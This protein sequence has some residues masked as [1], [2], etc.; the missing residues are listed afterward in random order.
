MATARPK[1]MTSD[2]LLQLYSEGV[3]GELIRGVLS[4]TMP[5]GEM[6]GKVVMRLARLMGNHIEPR[7]LG[8]L[9]GSDAGVLLET[10]P[11]TVRE[12]DVAYFSVER[13]PLDAANPGFSQV[14]PDLVVEV[15]SPNDSHREVN[16]KAMMWLRH[17]VRLVWLVHPA[18]RTVE[19][20]YGEARGGEA[21][22]GEARGPTLVDG[23][24]LDGS[25]V[26]P[27]FTCAVSDIFGP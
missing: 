12:P 10:D 14:T 20:H 27:G 4:E 19:V 26:L 17:G 22:G 25:D 7:Q 21:R 6:H 16:D 15:S 23:D 24:T 18:T 9:T 3:R 8:T 1:L 13:L 11:D 2:D 5:A